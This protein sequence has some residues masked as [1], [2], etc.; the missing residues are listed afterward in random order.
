MRFGRLD[1][2]V[3]DRGPWLPGIVWRAESLDARSP[4]APDAG[5]NA[6]DGDS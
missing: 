1:R 6:D 5:A 4:A 2:R 3:L